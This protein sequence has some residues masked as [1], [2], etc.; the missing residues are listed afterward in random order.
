MQSSPPGRTHRRAPQRRNPHRLGRERLDP[1]GRS[2]VACGTS[3][4]S[5]GAGRHHS[6]AI[7]TDGSILAWGRG[8]A[9]QLNAPPAPAGTSWVT[10]SG[11]L[12]HSVG[13][14][15][16]GT[17]VA[18]NP[19]PARGPRSS[20]G[21][22]LRPAL[23]G[24][25]AQPGP[26]QRRLG[27]RLGQQLPRPARHSDS[28]G[29]KVDPEGRGGFDPQ[30]GIPGRRIGPR[31]G[32][33]RARPVD[34]PRHPPEPP[35]SRW[36]AGSFLTVL[37]ADPVPASYCGSSPTSIAGCTP[38]VTASGMP[39]ATARLGLRARQ[40]SRARRQRRHLLLRPRRRGL[41]CR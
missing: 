8:T 7:L 28:S 24:R 14:L 1:D 10:V 32:K 13:L 31:V 18:G 21:S 19:G 16:D 22:L 9:G 37:R 34:V 12:H 35:T 39:S 20:G 2:T 40:R 4:I 36:A 23:R 30:R 15:S 17:A 26:A 11:G 33:Q 3:A 29:R 6:L 5:V 38:A 41:P 27:G 25:A